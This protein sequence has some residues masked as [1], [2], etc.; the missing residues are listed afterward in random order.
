M[1]LVV[2]VFLFPGCGDPVEENIQRL[3]LRMGDKE[4][5]K[6]ELLLAK[7]SAVAPLLAALD[8][9]RYAEGRVELVEVLFGLMMRVEDARIIRSLE[10]HLRKDPDPQMRA[11][12]AQGL[13][14]RKYA[15]STDALIAASRDTAALVRHS[16]LEAVGML[17]EYLTDE[18]FDAISLIA[19]EY[20][21]DPDP[22]VREQ[23]LLHAEGKVVKMH[24]IAA[25]AASRAQVVQAESLYKAA[26]DYSPES[27]RARYRLAR[28]YFDNT[29]RERGLRQMRRHGML[30]E[31]KRLPEAPVLDGRLDETAWSG[32]DGL[33]LPYVA[34]YFSAIASDLPTRVYVGYTDEALYLGFY[35]YDERPDSIV[36]EMTARDD[37]VWHEDSVEFFIDGDLDRR[38]YVHFIINARGTIYDEKLS[39]G[40]WTPGPSWN[41]NCAVATYIGDDFWSLEFRLPFGQEGVPQP[42]PGDFWGANFNRDFRGRSANQW[43]FTYGSFHQP[44]EFGLLEFK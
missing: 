16:A 3:G 37:Q 25:Q 44:D 9:P 5:A 7:G 13:G 12:I 38:S 24:E 2:L 17:K 30:T 42:R 40:R 34:N 43:V 39:S 23:A 14:R 22:Q 19:R 29:E 21:A 10:N 8:D 20:L 33:L 41:A 36:S 18:Q 11:E 31:A 15:A 1:L 35:G 6:L 26:L 32:I 27:W 4:E 28:F